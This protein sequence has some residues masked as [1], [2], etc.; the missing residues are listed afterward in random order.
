MNLDSLKKH[1]NKEQII[2]DASLL[3]QYGNDWLK[4]WQGKAGAVIFPK[5][6]SD[7]KNLVQWARKNKTQLI[8]SGGRTGLSGGATALKE[9]LVV[10][11]DKMN[12]ITD[13][14]PIE[15]TVDVEPGV[16]TQNLQ[17]F[18]LEKSCYFPISF[19]SE[20]TSQIG[21][22]ISTNAGGVHVLRYGSMRNQVL[23]LE[24]VTGKGDV[25]Q[26]ERGLIKNTAGYRLMELFIGSEGTLGFITKATLRLRTPPQKPIAF[27]FSL[28]TKDSLLELFQSFKKA[29]NP[30]A[31]EMFSDKALEYVMKHS[32]TPFPLNKR[33]SFY[34][35]MEIE[36]NETEKA[37]ALFEKA[38]ADGKIQ[39]GTLSQ[40]ETQF[41]DLWKLRENITE[42]ISPYTPYKND[43]CVRTSHMPHFL[44]EMEEL[45][46][47][48]YPD[49]EVIWFGHIGDGNLHINIL[50]PKEW[51]KQSFIKQCE[52]VND[53]LFSLVQ[54]YQGTIS[55]E[56]GIGILKKPYLNY[57]CS[58]EEIVFMKQIKKIFDPDSIMNSGK[59]FNL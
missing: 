11:F 12:R 59:I 5:S 29:V 6:T 45:F 54:K 18:A 57:S 51:T 21:G 2:E 3:S 1:F 53:L 38:L 41:K 40:N 47:K 43:I 36:S 52:K 7:V 25:L 58:P 50:K 28:E 19:A 56:H 46:K 31:F 17:E 22:N 34:V 27:L 10:S 24:V 30:L 37:L 39:D 20:G 13:F 14:N 32:Q 8:P 4:Q 9:E 42:S 55:A 33:S 35:L 49:F 15:Q 26:L 16:I 23:G 48:E 44:K